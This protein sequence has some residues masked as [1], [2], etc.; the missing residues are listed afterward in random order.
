MEMR[1]ALKPIAIPERGQDTQAWWT[2]SAW[3]L[4][5]ERDDEPALACMCN[6]LEARPE[7][8]ERDLSPGTSV[9]Y[10]LSP[11]SPQ[12]PIALDDRVLYPVWRY[13]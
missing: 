5:D 2:G 8:G 1:A 12:P 11:R 7:P 13:T 10:R 6:A 9:G 4:T 3:G